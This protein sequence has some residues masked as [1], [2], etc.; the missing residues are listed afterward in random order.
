LNDFFLHFLI[1]FAFLRHVIWFCYIVPYNFPSL[2]TFVVNLHAGLISAVRSTP[3][4]QN[5]FALGNNT[6]IQDLWLPYHAVSTD[7]SYNREVS[8]IVHGLQ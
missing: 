3:K 7:I 5:R 8:S 1:Q 4:T 2:V 6:R